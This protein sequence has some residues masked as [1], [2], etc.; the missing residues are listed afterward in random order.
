M[1]ERFLI[2]GHGGTLE[3]KRFKLG[4]G[5][6]VIY[7][8]ACGLPGT[9]STTNSPSIQYL[10]RHPEIITSYI[11]GNINKRNFP[12]ET[13]RFRVVGPNQYATNTI[14]GMSDNYNKYKNTPTYQ[15]HKYFHNTAG[16][17]KV[18]N[19]GNFIYL[20][21][22]DT[23]RTIR[24]IIGNNPGYY[25]IDACRVKTNATQEESNKL[26]SNLRTYGK[27]TTPLSTF[28]KKVNT[29]E[30][31]ILKK[32]AVSGKRKR[33]NNSTVRKQTVN[34]PIKRLKTSKTAREPFWMG[35]LNMNI[36]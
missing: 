14:V 15:W 5:Q 12:E 6:Y 17:W 21:G 35:I 18:P 13:L 32:I 19:T 33:T 29:Y 26:L 9:M 25:F 11:R 7:F 23:V 27:S 10:M 28:M 24:D 8:T 36:T 34:R 30:T 20:G 2:R 1:P 4:P 3:K 31:G 16:I 22:R